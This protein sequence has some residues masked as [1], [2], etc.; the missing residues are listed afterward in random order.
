MKFFEIKDYLSDLRAISII[1]GGRGIGKTYSTL[2]FLINENISFIYLR[3]TDTQLEECSGDF[4]NPF[5]K[6][7]SDK[8]YDIILTRSKKHSNIIDNKKEVNNI[9]GYGVALSTFENLRGV[10]LSNVKYVVFDEF[11]E[12]RKLTFDQ[13]KTFQNFY[14]TVN[15]NRELLGEEPL[16]CILLSNSQSLNN[17]I[18]MGY[19]IV[20]I[21]EG[22]TRSGQQ[23]HK[24]AG[25]LILLPESEISELKKDTAN[26]KMIKGTRIYEE[27]LN[28]KF[29]NDSF[30]GIIKRNLREYKP[31]VKI[32]NIYIYK[33]K[34]AAR[35]YACS[36]QALN[37]QEFNSR[38]NGMIFYRAY[39]HSLLMS[40]SAGN[41]EF[42]DFTIKSQLLELLK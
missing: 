35:Y 17:P 27:N 33:H 29:A 7:N 18:L 9:I 25:M 41:L 24:T 15:R 39:G 19:N 4:G 21:I 12:N 38:D 26:Y 5:K 32:D 22:M 8:G 1:I 20:P 13:F 23:K 30:Y 36:S 10:D 6:L 11:I 31:L 3:N 40:Y 37:I 34:A 16:K 28:N 2:D 14:E 42:S